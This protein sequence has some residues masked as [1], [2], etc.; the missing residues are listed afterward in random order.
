MN[1]EN[2]HKAELLFTEL[3]QLQAC[4]KICKENN[5]GLEIK[6]KDTSLHLLNYY[7]PRGFEVPKDVVEVMIKAGLEEI[8]NLIESKKAE[9][10]KL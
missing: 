5:V 6:S 4:E 2:I 1:V 7:I 3:K 8:S 10:N 9:I